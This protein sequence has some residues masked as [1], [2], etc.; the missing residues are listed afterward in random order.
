MMI[1]IKNNDI[2]CDSKEP[3]KLGNLSGVTNLKYIITLRDTDVY[4]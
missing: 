2:V 3:L 1:Y 4:V